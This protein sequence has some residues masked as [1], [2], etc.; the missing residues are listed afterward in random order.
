MQNRQFRHIANIADHLLE[1]EGLFLGL[2]ENNV[3]AKLGAV[4]FELDLAL[5]FLLV[6]ARPIGLAR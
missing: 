4:L 6:L 2:L 3:F 5:D 1:K